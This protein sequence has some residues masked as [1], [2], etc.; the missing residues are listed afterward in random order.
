MKYGYFFIK[1]PEIDNT[2]SIHKL[3]SLG[4]EKRYY[5]IDNI[6]CVFPDLDKLL[7]TLNKNDT[8]IIYE[9]DHLHLNLKRLNSLVDNF[10]SNNIQLVSILENIDT[11]RQDYNFF[12]ISLILERTSFQIH[13]ERTKKGFG[14]P[15]DPR[16]KSKMNENI[17]EKAKIKAIAAGRLYDKGY[18]LLL[19]KQMCGIKCTSTLY[20]YLKNVGIT[21]NRKRGRPKSKLESF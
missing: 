12:E 2:P 21:L 13:S 15:L 19:I 11:Y 17:S 10:S 1:N 18:A 16:K 20:K 5:D 9:L 8:L 6:D 7:E 14:R 3:K 4:A